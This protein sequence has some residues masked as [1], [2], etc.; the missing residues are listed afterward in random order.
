MNDIQ[1]FNNSEFGEVR[2]VLIGDDVWFIAKDICD[3]L[4]L[5]DVS[6]SVEKLEDDEKLIRKI[7]VSGQNRDI[8]IINESGLYTLIIRSNK[9]EARQF[10]KWV[11]AEV[12]PSIRKHGLYAVDELLNNPDMAIKAFQALKEERA[13]RIEAERKNAVLMHVSK[14][15]TATEIAKEIGLKSANELNRELE[16]RGIQFKV[17][18]TWV[19]KA[20]YADKGFFDIKQE[21]LDTGTVIYHR[22]I[23][24]NGRTFILEL[25]N[26]AA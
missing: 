17:N 11:T 9:P 26:K 14:T 12:L 22:R 19:P 8:L 13:A 3:I 1:V 18:N 20:D 23:T 2:T 7:F 10:R 16:K 24:Q 15:Y 21:V 4:G 5:S 25:F 6:R